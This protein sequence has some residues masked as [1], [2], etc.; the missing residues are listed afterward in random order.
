MKHQKNIAFYVE[1]LLLTLFILILMGV[2]VRMFAAA[3]SQ[4]L[5][6]KALTQAQQIAQNI[7]DTF[8]S[9]NS[10]EEFSSLSG[11]S[12]LRSY[13][14]H[15]QG[16]LQVD[17]AGAPTQKGSYMVSVD[18]I[19]LPRN[20][21]KVGQFVQLQLTITLSNQSEPL[22]DITCEK[23]LPSATPSS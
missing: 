17:S 11:I 22:V 16:E 14:N 19:S 20:T 15:Q 2:L 3:R 4:A 5:D 13:A 1:S 18:Y 9:C 8:Y 6:A 12:L 10:A 23:Y 21:G 7:S